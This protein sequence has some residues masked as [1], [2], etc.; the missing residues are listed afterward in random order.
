MSTCNILLIFLTVISQVKVFHY[1]VLT[2]IKSRLK[3]VLICQMMIPVSHYLVL[4]QYK[5]LTSLFLTH[6]LTYLSDENVL[7]ASK[8]P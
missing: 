8:N 6:F 2:L 3:L 5:S 1:L 7:F 4:T